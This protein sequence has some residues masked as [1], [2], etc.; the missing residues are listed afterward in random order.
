MA[1]NMKIKEASELSRLVAE[2]VL[3]LMTQRYALSTNRPKALAA[4]TGLSLS[5]V[6]RVLSADGE[7]RLSTI[8][9]LAKAF[10]MPPFQLLVPWDLLVGL[11]SKTLAPRR[12]PAYRGRD[13]ISPGVQRD[14]RRSRKAG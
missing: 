8:E 1:N 6:Q 4:E 5:S 10:G 14:A 3:R 11:S 7:S 2:N 9:T 13:R 12:Q